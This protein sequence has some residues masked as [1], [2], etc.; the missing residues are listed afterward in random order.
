ME[1]GDFYKKEN[2]YNFQ[3]IWNGKIG[4]IWKTRRLEKLYLKLNIHQQQ[5]VNL[6][7]ASFT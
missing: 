2:H 7:I 1:K 4:I 5:P 3:S 6:Y